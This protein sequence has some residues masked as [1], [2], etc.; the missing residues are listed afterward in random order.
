MKKLSTLP[1]VVA[2]LG[3]GLV[4]TSGCENDENRSGTHPEPDA[5]AADDSGLGPSVPP[6]GFLRPFAPPPAN[7]GNASVLFTIS[8]EAL[9]TEGVAFPPAPGQELRLVGGWEIQFERLVVTV[10]DLTLSANPDSDP[11]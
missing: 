5:E 3:G 1:I 9:A 7:P 11:N 2:L 8:G 6:P 10:D 4:A